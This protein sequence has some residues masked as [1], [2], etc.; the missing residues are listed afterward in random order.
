MTFQTKRK[1]NLTN[2]ALIK[3]TWKRKPKKEK[4]K[5]NETIKQGKN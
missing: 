4:C 1:L 5:I 3:E 2:C